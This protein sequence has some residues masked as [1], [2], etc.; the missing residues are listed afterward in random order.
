M[1]AGGVEHDV[2]DDA[3]AHEPLSELDAVA[4]GQIE[5]KHADLVR[6]AQGVGGGAT[7]DVPGLDPARQKRALQRACEQQV[8]FDEQ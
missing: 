5:V 1:L 3:G 6:S 7:G 2:V 4:I 8:V